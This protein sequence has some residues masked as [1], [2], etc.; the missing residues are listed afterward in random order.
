MK[1]LL[2]GLTL[3]LGLALSNCTPSV[4]TGT[5]YSQNCSSTYSFLSGCPS[6]FK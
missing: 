5:V 6:R 3:V 1:K 4:D 2:L